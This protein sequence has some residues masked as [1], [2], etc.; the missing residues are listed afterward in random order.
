M[1]RINHQSNLNHQENIIS[2]YSD[3]D[4]IRN[5]VVE[6]EIKF[7]I[8]NIR[9]ILLVRESVRKHIYWL[10]SIH[11]T[12]QYLEWIQYH[13]YQHFEIS[14]RKSHHQKFS[15][16]SSFSRSNFNHLSFSKIFQNSFYS[17]N[18]SIVL[19]YSFDELNISLEIKFRIITLMKFLLI[20]ST[21]K[22]IFSLESQ[23]ENT[24]IDH[25]K[26]IFFFCLSVN[27]NNRVRKSFNTSTKSSDWSSYLY[28]TLYLILVLRLSLVLENLQKLHLFV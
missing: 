19:F 27:F 22:S 3:N 24:S 10:S 21:L 2:K 17:F 5:F 20:T 9:D 15:I 6:S 13:Q 28:S 1:T 25:C 8:I 4:R 7:L 23:L 12:L 11:L 26:S 16:E 14:Y 18:I